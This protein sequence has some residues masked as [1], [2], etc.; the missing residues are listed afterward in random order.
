MAGDARRHPRGGSRLRHYVRYQALPQVLDGHSSCLH[1]QDLVAEITRFNDG[2]V[3]D[4]RHR[5]TFSPERARNTPRPF[6][7]SVLRTGGGRA[8][9]ERVSGIAPAVS[10]PP[11][12]GQ[13]KG[14][15]AGRIN[16]CLVCAC[17][18]ESS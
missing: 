8:R 2:A 6:I 9:R 14:R 7:K 18:C 12:P 4:Y 11:P 17:E 1:F 5:D 3:K 10:A 13:V 15:D 16:Y